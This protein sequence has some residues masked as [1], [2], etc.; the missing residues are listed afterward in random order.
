M[1]FAKGDQ[2]IHIDDP[3]DIGRIVGVCRTCN[4]LEQCAYPYY[5]VWISG[6]AE[7]FAED[8]LE[9]QSV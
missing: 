2:V 3:E 6:Q 4:D 9:L 5:V 7:W 1:R 8:Q